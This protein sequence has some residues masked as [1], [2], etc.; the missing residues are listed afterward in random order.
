L[1]HKKPFTR[2]YYQYRCGFDDKVAGKMAHACTKDT[3]LVHG[4]EATGATSDLVSFQRA[5]KT[6]AVATIGT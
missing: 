4:D 2:V 1:W 5:G 6:L 3:D